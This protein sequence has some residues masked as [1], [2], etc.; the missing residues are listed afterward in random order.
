VSASRPQLLVS[1]R[2]AAEA[3]E[4]LAGG[5]D[6]I[7]LKE[8]SRG[9]L[10]GVDARTAHEI[11]AAVAG[12]A[13]LSAAAGELH[14]WPDSAS[15]QLLNI[16]ELR[17]LKLGLAG[18]DGAQWRAQWRAAQ[19]QIVDAGKQLVAVIYADHAAAAAP[20][21]AEI[22]ALAADAGSPWVLWDT[23]N[24]STGPIHEHLDFDVL[25][26]MLTTARAAG[27]KTVVAGRLD[28]E[29][30]V[31]LPLREIDMIAVRG[32]ACRGS[33]DSAVCQLRVAKL[34]DQLARHDD[35]WSAPL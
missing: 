20:P 33:R 12:R 31:R 26:E 28:A 16:R 35:C 10:G 6:W 7:D 23:Y 15:K 11:A 17:L 34:R 14:D 9:A 22:L 3:L 32:A 8:P 21:P 1:V 19:R 30:L 27:M 18:C 5:A 2:D 13:P 4:A 24:K 25:R 29:R